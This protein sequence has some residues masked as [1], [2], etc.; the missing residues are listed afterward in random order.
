VLHA[1]RSTEPPSIRTLDRSLPRDLETICQRCMSKDVSQ[2]YQSAGELAD[3]LDRWLRGE[4]I[5][6]RPIGVFARTGRWIRRNPTVASLLGVI[7]GVLLLGTFVS[8]YFAIVSQRQATLARKEQRERALVQLNA[9]KT[10]VPASVPILIEAL[11]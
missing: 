9:L 1:V 10:S 7:G 8:T 5:K 4:P 2:R 6:A 11:R 3:E